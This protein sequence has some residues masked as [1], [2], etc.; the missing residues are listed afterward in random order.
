MENTVLIPEDSH[1]NVI[2][3]TSDVAHGASPFR[4][5]NASYILGGPS[6]SPT[7]RLVLLHRMRSR[8]VCLTSAATLSVLEHILMS[9]RTISA[10]RSA[11]AGRWRSS[12][13]AVVSRL[14]KDT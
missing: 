3:I 12:N 6:S 14:F 11:S 9:Q 7:S 5:A 4:V 2:D 1:I 8:P 13:I 10:V